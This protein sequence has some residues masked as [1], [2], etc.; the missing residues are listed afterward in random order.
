M[1]EEIR[2]FVRTALYALVIAAIYWFVSYEEAGTLL[3]IGIVVGSLLFVSVIAL[4]VRGARRELLPGRGARGNRA[5]GAA[6]RAL[7]FH[8]DPGD[9]PSAPLELTEE[10]LPRS[11]I[12]PV[13]VAL[14]AMLIGLGALYGAWFWIPGSAFGASALW[15]WSRQLDQ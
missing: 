2:F 1:A 10:P 3:L 13:A 14:A 5:L 15:G 6:D 9:G 11:S 8:D 7:G 4:T 12:W